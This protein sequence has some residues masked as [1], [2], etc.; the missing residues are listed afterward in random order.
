MEIEEHI[1]R[2]NG[3]GKRIHE[4]MD[5]YYDLCGD[6]HRLIFHHTRG[7]KFIAIMFGNDAEKIATQHVRDDYKGEIP[8]SYDD[9]WHFPEESTRK[10]EDAVNLA[11]A[12]ERALSKDVGASICADCA[13]S[14]F[15]G[16]KCVL[17]GTGWQC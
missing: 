3:I 6:N 5:Q 9:Y 1:K 12:V 14:K 15:R 10:Y 17:P 11:K 2:T 7:I 4:F 13:K 8:D 16:G